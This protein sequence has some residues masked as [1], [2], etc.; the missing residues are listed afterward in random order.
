MIKAYN[1]YHRHDFHTLKLSFSACIYLLVIWFELPLLVVL[2]KITVRRRMHCLLVFK[3]LFISPFFCVFLNVCIYSLSSL[4]APN[5]KFRV[6]LDFT[7][8]RC[9][10][11]Y[12][13]N[14]E[15]ELLLYNISMAEKEPSTGDV[16]QKGAFHGWRTTCQCRTHLFLAGPVLQVLEKRPQCLELDKRPQ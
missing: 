11:N 16:A 15:E 4:F 13:F 10:K 7:L 14:S 12:L 2:L 9:G 8:I 3:D 1:S 6:Y 5:P